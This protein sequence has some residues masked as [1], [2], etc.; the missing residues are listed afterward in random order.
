MSAT[1]AT[2]DWL[3]F[4][5][6][7]YLAGFIAEGGSSVKFV[8]PLGQT[9]TDSV[10]LQFSSR[11]KQQDV[12]CAAVDSANCKV[13]LI[14]Q[15]FFTVAQ[16]VPWIESVH[17]VLSKLAADVGYKTPERLDGVVSFGQAIAEAN[18]VNQSVVLMDM[19]RQL[20]NVVKDTSMAKDF[21]V[22]MTQ[23]CLGELRG[24][25]DG[26]LI[27][28]AL[29]GWLT[30]T[31]RSIGAVKR[32]HIFSSI[33]RTN[34]R[35]HLRSLTAWVKFAGYAGTAI[36]VDIDQLLVA[37]KPTSSDRLFYTRAA[38][39]DAYEVMRQFIDD[40]DRA[41]ACLLVILASREFL[42]D[43]LR[44]RGLGAYEALKFRVFDE[45]HDRRR[46]NP[47]AALVRLSAAAN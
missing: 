31:N 47:M 22:A 27:R 45:V 9:G 16:Q 42:E 1:I 3:D 6:R 29:L 15:L 40:T 10:A 38:V 18:Q 35:H 28:D 43:E 33:S 39:L 30:G 37:R 12:I 5:S 25:E 44:G 23:L 13:H 2:G 8:V 24:G 4:V 17:R 11:A 21:R 36:V 46:A 19:R 26:H 34:A 20:G 14:E 32:Y 7:E 41:Q